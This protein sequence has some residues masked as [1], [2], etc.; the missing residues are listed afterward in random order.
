MSLI[1][2]FIRAVVPALL[3]TVVLAACSAIP[4][5]FRPN[6]EP[7]PTPSTSAGSIDLR[8]T[9][10]VYEHNPALCDQPTMV[11]ITVENAGSASSPET[12]LAANYHYPVA[13]HTNW[14]WQSTLFVPALAAGQSQ[15]I[16]FGSTFAIPGMAHISC[17][18]S[19]TGVTMPRKRRIQQHP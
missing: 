2:K 10:I 15:V 1:L 13:S 12:T 18:P 3:P 7:T 11:H 8:V 17:A 4:D 6:T 19:R 14:I 16:S 9:D 5:L